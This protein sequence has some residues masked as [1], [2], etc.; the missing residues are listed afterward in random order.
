MFAFGVLALTLAPSTPKA[1]S[2]KRLDSW[3]S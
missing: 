3:K 2:V 1:E